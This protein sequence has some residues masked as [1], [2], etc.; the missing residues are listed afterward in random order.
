MSA[1][2]RGEILDSRHV[3]RYPLME[4]VYADRYTTVYRV[5][6]EESASLPKGV[7]RVYTK[8]RGMVR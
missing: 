5:L 3:D 1:A 6:D 4:K 8:A 2:E 7:E